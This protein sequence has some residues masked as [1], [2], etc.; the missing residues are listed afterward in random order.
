M[1]Y[2]PE[3]EGDW[4]QLSLEWVQARHGGEL[5]SVLQQLRLLRNSVFFAASSSNKIN[6][7]TQG[8]KTGLK[9]NRA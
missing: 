9:S 2:T 6:R 4:T 1:A 5:L 7:Y 3:G 8:R